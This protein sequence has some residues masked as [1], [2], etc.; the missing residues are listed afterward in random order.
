M[1]MRKGENIVKYEENQLANVILCEPWRQD[2][3]LDK[4]EG[5]FEVCRMAEIRKKEILP[6]SQFVT[7]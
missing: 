6:S 1:S 5:K 2:S 4:L 7:T 3:Y